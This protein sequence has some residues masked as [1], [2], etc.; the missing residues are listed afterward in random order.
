MMLIVV[1]YCTENGIDVLFCPLGRPKGSREN[2][3]NV[4]G[5]RFC[6]AR[7]DVYVRNVST[8]RV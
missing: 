7:D 8:T 1:D 2:E 4:D 6:V 5:L 3:N